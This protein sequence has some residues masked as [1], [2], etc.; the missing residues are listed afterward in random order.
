[1]HLYYKDNHCCVL[2]SL[3]FFSQETIV[4]VATGSASINHD[5]LAVF[6]LGVKGQ[7]ENY[8]LS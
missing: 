6:R 3:L 1:M 2:H 7:V 5:S 4:F 8:F